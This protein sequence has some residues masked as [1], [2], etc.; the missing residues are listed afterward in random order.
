MP[1][2]YEACKAA[3]VSALGCPDTNV[4]R[5]GD[6]IPF[7]GPKS[8]FA[9]GNTLF[10]LSATPRRTDRTLT[11]ERVYGATPALSKEII[12][13]ARFVILEV[14]AESYNGEDAAEALEQLLL[15]LDDPDPREILRA[16]CVSYLGGFSEVVEVEAFADN[17]EISSAVLE[18]EMFYT[19]SR[20]RQLGA[21]VD[22]N[23]P[24]SGTNDPDYIATADPLTHE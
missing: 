20:E 19:I 23:N 14:R 21:L 2:P 9:F 11:R 3:I 17:R 7:V 10:T 15:S 16:A 1:F 5:S 6:P 24:S 4:I 12:S 18:L 8:A 22:P 13:T